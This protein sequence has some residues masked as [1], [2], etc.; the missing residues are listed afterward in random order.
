MVTIVACLPRDAAETVLGA[1]QQAMTEVPADPADDSAESR[2][3]DA[4]ELLAHSYLAGNAARPPTETVVHVD[5]EQLADPD[6]SPVLERLICD[7]GLR[8]VVHEAD[9]TNGS[10]ASPGRSPSGCAGSSTEETKGAGSQVAPT[11]RIITCITSS[12]S[13]PVALLTPT[14]A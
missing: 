13:P 5:A 12:R 3:A 7:T 9:G 2:R 10:V 6:R 1:L 4:L 8:V 11:V 14:T